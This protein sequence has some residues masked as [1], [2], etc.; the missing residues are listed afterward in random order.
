MRTVNPSQAAAISRKLGVL[1]LGSHALPR[2]LREH[3]TPV[4][5]EQLLS[6]PLIGFDK[7]PSI[8]RMPK[9]SIPVTRGLFS[10]RCDSDYGQYAAL[11]A[12][13]GIAASEAG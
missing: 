3:D 5:A 7:V 11:K 6:H 8:S 12:A 1:H 9:M 4:T 2:C 10:F 13:Y